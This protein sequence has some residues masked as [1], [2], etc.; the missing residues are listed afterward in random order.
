MDRVLR[1]ALPD[2]ESSSSTP[3]SKCF[4]M[5]PGC[6]RAFGLLLQ[7]PGQARVARHMCT[8]SGSK[9]LLGPNQQDAQRWFRHQSPTKVL[10]GFVWWAHY[11]FVSTC[12]PPQKRSRAR[13]GF[14]D[15]QRS[16]SRRSVD[17][18]MAESQTIR[19]L[20]CCDEL[21]GVCKSG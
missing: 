21:H 10:L 1:N 2:E 16:R 4:R 19:S 3:G 18:Y 20:R 8:Q 13:T 7:E 11:W 14:S 9:E 17:L 15:A 5:Q 6:T 12:P